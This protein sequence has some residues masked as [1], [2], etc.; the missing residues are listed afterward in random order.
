MNSVIMHSLIDII[1]GLVL[2]YCICKEEEIISNIKLDELGDSFLSKACEVGFIYFV[3]GT[4]TSIDDIFMSEK[5][6]A[7]IIIELVY[8]IMGFIALFAILDCIKMIRFI[9]G[10][11]VPEA[12]KEKVVK[13][14]WGDTFTV[15]KLICIED[16]EIRKWL[17]EN[18]E[19]PLMKI[20]RADL[21]IKYFYSELRKTY[22][23]FIPEIKAIYQDLVEWEKLYE[24]AA[25]DDWNEEKTSYLKEVFYKKSDMLLKKIDAMEQTVTKIVDMEKQHEKHDREAFKEKVDAEV[26]RNII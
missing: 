25:H 16:A 4:V 3:A 19:L 12:I 8:I 14:I 10:T 24:K 11:W 5:G 7:Y 22:R 18:V 20:E 1:I 23:S 21:R 6:I 15:T 13:V 9:R 26:F 17:K 2:A